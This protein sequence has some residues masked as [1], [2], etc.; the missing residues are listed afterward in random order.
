M[1]KGKI[2]VV[3]DEIY[4]VHILDFSLGMEGYEV[5]TALDGEQALEKARA[6]KPDLIVLDIMMPKL[7]GY[8][9]CKRLKA[10]DDT[11]DIPVIL[12]S[13]KGRNVDQKVGFE[14]GADDY[15]T[16][17]FSPRKL[18]ERINAMLG[19]TN[20]LAA[21]A[22]LDLRPRRDAFRRTSR[23]PRRAA[24]A[25]SRQ[26]LLAAA[27]PAAAIS[28]SRG[29]ATR[30]PRTPPESAASPWPFAEVALPLPLRQHV[31]LSRARGARG[32]TRCRARRCEVPFRGRSARGVIV[33]A[34]RRAAS[35]RRCASS[36]SVL[37]RAA[38]R[39]APARARALDRRVL[40][41][42]ARRGAGRGAARRARGLR[43][44]PRA[45][46]R[47]RGS[48]LR[49]ALPERVTLTRAQ[50]TATAA[51]EVAI[52]AGAFAPFLLHGV[53]ASGKT[54]VYLRAAQRGARGGRPDA[55]AG[56]RDRAR[57]ADRGAVP[58]SASAARVGV[59]HCYL[60]V[61]RAAAQLGAGAPRRAR[62][63]GG[64]ALGGVR[65]AAEP[66]ARDRGR[67][68]RARLQAER[69][70]ALPR[71]RRRGAPRAD[72]GHSG[73]AGLGDAGLESLAN[74][75]RGKYTRLALPE[76]VDRRALPDGARG[77]PAP[78]RR[79][80]RAAV[81]A[82]ARGA[83]RA[84]RARRAGAAVAQPPRA[85]APRAVPRLR[86]GARMP[87]TATSRSRCTSRR[88]SCAATT[89]TIARPRPRCARSATLPLLRLGGAGTQRA[90]REL[91]QRVPE[92][93]RAAPRHRRRARSRRARATCSS[94]SRAARPTCC[95]ARR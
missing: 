91:A 56:A 87:A 50:R 28:A 4:I 41:G 69:A 2:L 57:L 5:L 13:A 67:G 82:A 58:R 26:V 73:G 63:G 70:A 62:R 75:A 74:A 94:A 72:A 25:H 66:E 47:G 76:R 54:E 12:L 79:G 44:Q 49:L 21:H 52:A 17:P 90:E 23:G 45:D 84:A 77:G 43:R 37:G 16:K 51:I 39:R 24:S 27:S 33:D 30:V 81:A 85:L 34:R 14:V 3:D 10:D 11:K 18:V 19:Q 29:H 64:R 20:S 48:G 22:G 65:A 9:T 93:A 78:R 31:H 68:A 1:A 92:G 83:R 71:P 86:L 46:A 42:A 35:S 40:R 88:T 53:T 8:E 15:I 55:G 38:A 6:E 36:A 61:G 59:L 95:S 89:A 80:R 60:A 32:A 7:D